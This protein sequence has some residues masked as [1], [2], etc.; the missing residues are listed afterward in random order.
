MTKRN[1]ILC[2]CLAILATAAV[3][4]FLLYPHTTGPV[5]PRSGDAHIQAVELRADGELRVWS[6]KTEEDREKELVIL[7]F[8]AESR[9]RHLLPNHETDWSGDA[10]QRQYMLIVIQNG[11]N[12]VNIDLVQDAVVKALQH[13]ESLREP[14]AVRSWFYRILVRECLSFLR[15]NRR[16]IY[17]AEPPE[18]IQSSQESA[19][20]DREALQQAIDRLSPKLKTVVLLRFYEEMQLSEIAEI[21]GT[22]LS[23]VKSRL[24]KGLK[25]LRES[26]QEG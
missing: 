24:Y 22:N 18:Q 20:E 7:D 21:T 10:S 25:K 2:L 11:S 14:E 3:A 9:Q 8:L 16:V 23:T 6:P 4:F 17:L 13:W 15:Q 1:R 12:L 26:L 19:L 5:L